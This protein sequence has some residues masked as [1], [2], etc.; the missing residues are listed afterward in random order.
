[1][2]NYKV[3]VPERPALGRLSRK[4][5]TAGLIVGLVATLAV[6]VTIYATTCAVCTLV[7]HLYYNCCLCCNPVFICWEK[8]YTP[9]IPMCVTGPGTSG[10]TCGASSTV[11]CG[12]VTYITFG[13]DVPSDTCQKLCHTSSPTTTTY[14]Y[15]VQKCFTTSGTCSTTSVSF[16][17]LAP[18]GPCP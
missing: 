2:N 8:A 11:Q 16:N 5:I 14:S 9:Y 1:M 7:D 17:E 15:A 18:Q 10:Y 6:P 12:Q 3:K 4:L 13:C